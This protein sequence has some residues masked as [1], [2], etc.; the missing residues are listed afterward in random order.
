[1]Q[2]HQLKIAPSP[3]SLAQRKKSVDLH[4]PIHKFRLGDES[5]VSIFLELSKIQAILLFMD[6]CS[7]KQA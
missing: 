5:L 4:F 6:L 1:M 3:K 7:T 2:S